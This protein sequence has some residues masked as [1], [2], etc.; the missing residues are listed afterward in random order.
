MD[1][2]TNSVLA[3]DRGGDKTDRIPLMLAI[4]LQR[5]VEQN[6]T[7]VKEIGELAGVSP[8]TVYRWIAGQSQP[9]FNAI[10][11]LI[12]HL[13]NPQA[14]D[15]LIS[16]LTTGTGWRLTRQILDLDVNHDGRVDT[17]DA[18]DAAIRAVHAAGDSLRAVR[19]SARDGVVSREEA[20]A[21]IAQL[22]EVIGQS[23]LVQEV[24]L[25]LVEARKKRR[26]ARVVV[27]R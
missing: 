1:R 13:P 7:T 16:L 3:V 10:R 24:M 25:R 6:L 9:D 26:A 14:Q 11:L 19:D 5:L 17:D 12:R 20:V 2:K 22:N 23:E 27:R 8:S 18:L 21:L 4:T 15:A